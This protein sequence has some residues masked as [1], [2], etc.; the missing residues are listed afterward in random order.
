MVLFHLA[1]I[2][3]PQHEFVI[4]DSLGKIVSHTSQSIP[5]SNHFMVGF[6]L[7]PVGHQILNLCRFREVTFVCFQGKL[8]QNDWCNTCSITNRMSQ[9]LDPL[10]WCTAQTWLK[11]CLFWYQGEGFLHIIEENLIIIRTP[12]L[13]C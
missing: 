5:L 13:F 3:K 12:L 8:G 6:D 10:Y 9:I 4:L 1:M 7:I 11:S 2:H